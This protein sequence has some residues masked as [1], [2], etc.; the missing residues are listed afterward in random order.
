MEKVNNE[1]LDTSAEILECTERK[2]QGKV[3]ENIFGEIELT[4]VA[5]ETKIEEVKKI[6]EIIFS[7]YTKLCDPKLITQEIRH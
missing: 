2:F 7:L 1:D 4:Q 5:L 3:N 6:H